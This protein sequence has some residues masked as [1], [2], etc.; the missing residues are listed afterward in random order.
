MFQNSH[1][2]NDNFETKFLNSTIAKFYGR[3]KTKFVNFFIEI[4]IDFI[5]ET[6]GKTLN[7]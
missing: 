3:I 4:G 2:I 1:W 6:E 7:N 5:A